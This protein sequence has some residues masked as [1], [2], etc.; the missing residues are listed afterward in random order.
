MLINI[1]YSFLSSDK[2]VVHNGIVEG[3]YIFAFY[4]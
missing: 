3:Y 2:Q 1:F 4:A